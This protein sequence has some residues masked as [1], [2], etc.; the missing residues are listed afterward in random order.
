MSRAVCVA[1]AVGASVAAAIVIADLVRG[2]E[3][4]GITFLLFLAV[5]TLAVGQLWGI[6]ILVARQ[7]RATG[8]R[9]R[10]W[11]R[12]SM[13]RDPRRFFFNGLP[14][15]QANALLA[16]ATLAGVSASTAAPHFSSGTPT[17]P[18]R[19]CP[20]R[21][22]EGGDYTC[23][24]RSTYFAAGAASQRFATSIVGAFFVI[25]FG[26][27]AAELSRRRRSAD[28]TAAES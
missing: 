13:E 5:P 22:E 20:Y 11:M 12:R 2:R 27:A 10:G 6:A 19:R 4:T 14:L 16:V 7:D 8:D 24:S 26:I 3:I 25:Q 18:S 21:L 23:V 15:A 28:G 1:T 17:S 9:P